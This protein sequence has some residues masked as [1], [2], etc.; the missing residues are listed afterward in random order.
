MAFK[1]IIVGGSVAG[2]SLANMLEKA[3]IDYVLLEGYSEIAP[4]VGASIGLLPNGL[5]ILDQLG[6]YEAYRA[7]AE[8]QVY[9]QAYLRES[10]GK[11]YGYQ[12]DLMAV[13]EK[14]LGYP[15]I[16]IDRMMLLQ[17]LYAN[18]KQKERVLT[19]KRVVSVDF[20]VS[21]VRVTTKDNSVFEGDLVVGADGIHST[22]RKEMWRNA[23]AGCFPRGEDAR[24]PA[25]T[26]CVFG[27]SKRPKNYPGVSQQ[28]TLNKGHSYYVM[29]APGD[30]IYWFLF[31]ALDPTLYGQDIP[32]Y[33]K[34]D[35]DELVK[36]HLEDQV[37]ENIKFGEIYDARIATTL[38]P[39]QTYVFEKWHHRRIITI[40]DSAHK[41]DPVTGQGG[42]GAIESAALLVNGLLRKLDEN[43][44]GLSEKQVE[45]VLAEVYAGR[46]DRAQNVVAQ[47]YWLQDV[48][49]QQNAVS[50]FISR[51]LMP[52]LGS[53]GV[54]YRGVEFCAPATRL[55]RFEVPYR[56]RAVPFDDELPARPI[57]LVKSIH[58]LFTIM[59]LALLCLVSVGAVQPPRIVDLAVDALS[60]SGGK[61]PSMLSA[62]TFVIN[63]ASLLAMA[64]VESNR[65]GNQLTSLVFTGIF[66]VVNKFL[67]PRVMGP[68]TCIFAHFASGSIIGRHLPV[69]TARMV[70]PI[71]VVGYLVPAALALH[72]LD[73]QAIAIWKGAP[74]LCFLL[75]RSLAASGR[76]ELEADRKKFRNLFTKADLPIIR[77]IHCVALGVSA[78]AHVVNIA[79]L[80]LGATL[81]FGGSKDTMAALG[82]SRYDGLIFTLSS[83]FLSLGA[84]SWNLRLSGYITTKRALQSSLAIIASI[85]VVGPAATVAA[86][87]IWRET[88]LTSL[89]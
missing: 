54:L 48:F 61:S 82:M 7:K 53:F 49:T 69:E 17:V 57:K 70:L 21:G 47:G 56:P 3:G 27:I 8:D 20:T 4:Q 71:V 23:P 40:G 51:Y 45:S 83:L 41:V 86:M 59:A 58:K 55:E 16:F 73:S 2:L 42:N 79:S 75:A 31:V 72:S 88:V 30:R 43:P 62:A 24:V 68:L 12:H 85:F 32:R 1:I 80:G 29:A 76:S 60:S 78:A 34:H 35:E 19:S 74:L 15:M 9:Q 33:T 22:V 5:R 52:A 18:L 64:L 38:A 67:G 65:A 39:L 25:S 6:C 84:A 81:L 13:W 37:T 77:L 10:N 14:M 44:D 87:A 89:A 28:N 63:W 36:Q 11:I 26:K 50:G 66:A 46:F